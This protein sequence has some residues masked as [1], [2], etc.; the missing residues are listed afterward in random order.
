MGSKGV[1]FFTWDAIR[2]WNFVEIMVSSILT[3]PFFAWAAPILRDPVKFSQQ[4]I[5]V[6][7][8]KVQRVCDFKIYAT[9]FLPLYCQAI[10]DNECVTDVGLVI[11][12]LYPEWTCVTS[13]ECSL[14]SN[15]AEWLSWRTLTA[16]STASCFRG[17]S[18]A[19]S[20]SPR[21][22]PWASHLSWKDL[23][24]R[25]IDPCPSWCQSSLRGLADQSCLW[26][27][28]FRPTLSQTGLASQHHFSEMLCGTCPVP[29]PRDLLWRFGKNCQIAW[30]RPTWNVHHHERALFYKEY[31]ILTITCNWLSIQL[32]V[33]SIHCK[34]AC[35]WWRIF[36]VD[37][38]QQSEK[39]YL[40]MSHSCGTPHHTHLATY[41]LVVNFQCKLHLGAPIVTTFGHN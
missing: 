14:S 39:A 24:V 19:S 29:Y 34:I 7:A 35:T 11:H 31:F 23:R 5:A 1:F 16:L 40:G 38:V 13:T 4:E 3:R 27:S 37:L 17:V 6:S 26:P 18:R 12:L 33:Q 10:Q 22:A 25:G 30:Q 2:Q 15:D 8:L 21:A 41:E 20:S 32:S 9:T 36:H 28:L